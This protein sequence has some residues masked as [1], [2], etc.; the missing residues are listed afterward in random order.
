MVHIF[1]WWPCFLSRKLRQLGF[2]DLGVSSFAPSRINLV[3]SLKN[4]WYEWFSYFAVLWYAKSFTIIIIIAFAGV[5]F[6][7]GW[8]WSSCPMNPRSFPVSWGLSVEV[9]VC[10]LVIII[11]YEN[12]RCLKQFKLCYWRE[13]ML[14]VHPFFDRV[15]V[16]ACSCHFGGHRFSFPN[17][18]RRAWPAALTQAMII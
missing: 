11:S 13:I 6:L 4:S 17:D 5:E 8:S 12:S 10:S 15:P 1:K 9:Y 3:V 18:Q 7:L 16:H 14:F 2:W